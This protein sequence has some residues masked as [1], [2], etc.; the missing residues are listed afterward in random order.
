MHEV[1]VTWT[2]WLIPHLIANN[3]ALVDMMLMAWWIVLAI[4][5]CLKWMWAIDIAT[6]F[7]TLV[8][9]ITTTVLV[10]CRESLKILLSLHRWE[11]LTLLILW[12]T[13]LK[14]R[15]LEKISTNWKPRVNSLC[16]GLNAGKIPLR[17]LLPSTMEHLTFKS[18]L[19]GQI[20]QGKTMQ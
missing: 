5:F 3:S 16:R 19:R 10:F 18:L 14:E 11:T 9:D 17:Q 12:S 6:L 2:T 15:Q 4:M 20:I 7:L 1:S 8:S 13:V